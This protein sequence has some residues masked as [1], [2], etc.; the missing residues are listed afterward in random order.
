MAMIENLLVSFSTAVPG[1]NFAFTLLVAVSESYRYIKVHKIQIQ[2]LI[3]R[4]FR[5]LQTIDSICTQNQLPAYLQEHINVFNSVLTELQTFVSEVKDQHVLRKLINNAGITAEIDGF[6]AKLTRLATDMNLAMEVNMREWKSEDQQDREEDER[7]FQTLLLQLRQQENR[8]VEAVGINSRQIL[9][10]VQA[11]ERRLD[12]DFLGKVEKLFASRLLSEL[13]QRSGPNSKVDVQPWS[14]SSWEIQTESQPIASG[15]YGEIYKGKWL[16]TTQVAVKKIKVDQL[17]TNKK[18]ETFNREVRVW[19][20]LRHP[21]IIQLFGACDTAERPFIIMPFMPNGTALRYIENSPE[22]RFRLIYEIACGMNY[23]HRNSIV[24]GDLKAINILVDDNGKAKIIDF[25]FAMVKSISA[26]MSKFA[27]YGTRRWT[28]PELLRN[29]RGGRSFKSD[30][31]AFAITCYEIISL[32]DT[33][34]M[35]IREEDVAEIVKD[36]GRPEPRPADCP[37]VIWS[38]INECWQDNPSVRPDFS[39]IATQLEVLLCVKR[40]SHNSNRLNQDGSQD[41]A[42]NPNQTRK[43]RRPDVATS[44]GPPLYKSVEEKPLPTR[45]MQAERVHRSSHHPSTNLTG[46]QQLHQD[47][48]IYPGNQRRLLAVDA[49]QSGYYQQSQPVPNMQSGNIVTSQRPTS[50]FQ[51][52]TPIRSLNQGPAPIDCP[53]CG[54]RGMTAVNF[55][56]G[57]STHVWAFAACLCLGLGCIPYFMNSAKDVVHRCTSCGTALAKWHRNGG[58][59]ELLVHGIG[60][61]MSYR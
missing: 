45:D 55:E 3:E 14:I 23:L 17:D 28:A 26:T 47:P 40:T 22:S 9:E 35:E 18:R 24:H 33:P 31:Y 5:L 11:L 56:T 60:Q 16:G 42:N 37:D 38:L 36:G 46:M 13:R 34:Y 59:T 2:R 10:A 58:N 1:L 61:N 19:Y 12:G 21:N 25:G 8:L 54:V 32:G 7:N 29:P 57:S 30:I 53:M 4:H 44:S 39:T 51:A 49:M 15:G 20:P 43:N 52:V 48:G 50:I 27:G 6:H 41:C